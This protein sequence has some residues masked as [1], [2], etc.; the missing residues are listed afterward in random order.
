MLMD[1][2]C[3]AVHFA[4]DECFTV[5]SSASQGSALVAWLRTDVVHFLPP[6]A[7]FFSDICLVLE[8]IVEVVCCR[9]TELQ[10]NLYRHFIHSKNV[11]F[12]T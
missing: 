4:Q 11:K 6:S 5:K 1:S 10:T 8:Q 7:R 2:L 3:S 9:L 12:R